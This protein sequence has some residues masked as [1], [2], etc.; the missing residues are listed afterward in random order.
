MERWR[1]ERDGHAGGQSTTEP[2]SRVRNRR[3]GTRTEEEGREGG[4][5][6]RGAGKGEAESKVGPRVAEHQ[7]RHGNA[8]GEAQRIAGYVD[9][10]AHSVERCLTPAGHDILLRPREVGDAR[11]VHH[12]A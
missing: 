4:T 6:Q 8:D 10:L 12:G 7:T 9:H 5:G 2:V 3:D 11:V 1:Q